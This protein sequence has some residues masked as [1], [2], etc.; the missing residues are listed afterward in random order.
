MKPL[1]CEAAQGLSRFLELLQ[2][3]LR[4]GTLVKAVLADLRLD[5]D[6]SR[7]TLRPVT[8]RG[9]A[10]LAVGYSY[11]TRDETRTLPMAET[12]LWLS[13]TLGT[14]ALA[15]HLILTQGEIHA[16][17]D[18]KGR[19]LISGGQTTLRPPPAPDHNR[20]KKRWVDSSRPWLRELG[21]TDPSGKPIPS[22]AHKWKQINRFIEIVNGALVESDKENWS[23]ASIIDFGAGKGYLTFALHDHIATA[24]SAEP[25]TLGIEIRPQLVEMC[26]GIAQDVGF[27]KLRFEV[28]E[29]GSG[30]PPAVDL[31]IALHA[32]DVATDMALGMGIKGRANII[33]CSPCCHKEI[34]PQMETPD[35]LADILRYGVHAG[36]MAEMLTDT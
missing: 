31:L 30:A 36:A 33:V 4:Q 13:N 7:I 3:H 21:I 2:E 10:H 32:C 1:N 34:R 17:W 20:S 24:F 11:K 26:N 16:K 15:A 29:L 22:M 8:V 23:D 25:R 18:K 5:P 19:C 9:D 28:G 27:S 35:E 12:L 14:H 6:L